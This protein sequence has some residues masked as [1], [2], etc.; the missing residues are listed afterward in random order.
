MSVQSRTTGKFMQENIY[1]ELTL[2]ILKWVLGFRTSLFEL[3]HWPPT[4]TI[5]QGMT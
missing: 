2:W 1:G 3:S 4:V 5:A